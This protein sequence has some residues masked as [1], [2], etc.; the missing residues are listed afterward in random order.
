MSE[1][2]TPLFSGIVAA[3]IW[4]EP[5]HVRL[6]W[7][8]VLAIKDRK[9]FVGVSVPGLARM[10]NVTRD[11][12]EDALKRFESPDPDSKCQDNEGRRIKRVEGGW[13]VLGHDR[14]Q[15]KMREACAAVKNAA[16]QKRFR[17]RHPD[18]MKPTMAKTAAEALAEKTGV[19]PNDNPK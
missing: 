18:G 19:M 7:I 8:T 11:E 3:S 17:E 1:T 15:G 5:Y 13:L 10:A 14:N 16:R 6:V 4:S 9:G 12:C 2:W